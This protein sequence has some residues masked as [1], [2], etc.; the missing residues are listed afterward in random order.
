MQGAMRRPRSWLLLRL[1]DT[2]ALLLMGTILLVA[3]VGAVILETFGT[4][5]LSCLGLDSGGP[6][7][8]CS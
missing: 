7:G 1:Q 6:R 4:S 3:L 8:S 5:A 2:G